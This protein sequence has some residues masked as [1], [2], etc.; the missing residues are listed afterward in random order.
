MA[1]FMMKTV[2]GALM[3]AL[4][5]EREKAG[6]VIKQLA[7]KYRYQE[8]G[9]AQFVPAPIANVSSP[10]VRCGELAFK[11]AD[12]QRTNYPCKFQVP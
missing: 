8:S 2:A 6:G 7:A 12:Q 5:Q 3:V 4:D 11:F 9:G 1:E 10:T